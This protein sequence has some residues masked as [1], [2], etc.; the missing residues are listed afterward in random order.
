MRPTEVLQEIRKMRFEEA[1]GA[2]TVGL[3]LVPVANV[4][5][6]AGL[7][8]ETDVAALATPATDIAVNANVPKSN[9]FTDLQHDSLL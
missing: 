4:D 9:V 6:S 2:W 8:Q 3:T 5:P 1:Y 7:S